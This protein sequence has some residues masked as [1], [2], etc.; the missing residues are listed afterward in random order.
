MPA[1]SEW[2]DSRYTGLFRSGNALA[3]RPHDPRVYIWGGEPAFPFR[4]NPLVGGAGWTVEAARLAGVGEAIE[5]WATHALPQ[6]TAVETCFLDWSSDEPAVDPILWVGFHSDQ[7]ARLP[8]EPLTRATVCRWI[9]F[10]QAGSGGTVWVPGELAFMNLS[11]DASPRFGPTISTG[12]SAHRTPQEAYARGLWE[13]VE[14]DAVV[15]AWWGAYS[16]F[17]HHGQNVFS[18]LD[19]PT[20]HL[21]RPNLTYRFFRVGS[22]FSDNVTVVTLQGEDHEGPIFSC[23]SACR[24]TLAESWAKALL[25]AVQGRHYARFLR[26]GPTPEGLPRSFAEHA[27]YYTFFPK[28][29]ER[30]PFSRARSEE[31]RDPAVGE[32]LAELSSRLPH[33]PLFRFMTPPQLAEKGLDWAVIRVM[34]P[35]LQPLHGDHHLPFLGGRLWGER[36]VSDY[37]DIPPHPFP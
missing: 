1:L 33:P 27:A 19:T 28:M 35:G 24:A 26:A 31:W 25:E 12:W 15:G 11:P 30:T 8:F 32:T 2:A 17:E 22:P 36:P 37:M 23:G 29:L 34:V 13:L 16:L 7:Y 20:E 5:R 14:R 21:A 3:P 6:D 10:R 4:A 9:R 18:L